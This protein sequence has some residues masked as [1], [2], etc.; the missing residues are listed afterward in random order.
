M[1]RDRRFSRSRTFFAPRSRPTL[2][3]GRAAAVAERALEDLLGVADDR[4]E[5]GRHPRD[6]GLIISRQGK[7]SFVRQRT[8]RPVGLRPHIEQAFEEQRVTI[9]FAGFSGETLNGAIQEP[10]DKIRVGRL[11]PDEIGTE[12][13]CRICRCRSAYP[14]SQQGRRRR[15]GT[16]ALG[17]DCSSNQRSATRSRSWPIWALS[18]RRR[19]GAHVPHEPA[20]RAFII[21]GDEIFS[22]F[23]L[24]LKHKVMIY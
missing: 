8:E 2:R 11:T 22:G 15:T 13:S 6:E 1:T 12:C 5:G 19:N 24:A 20:V 23:Y 16:S 14:R 17:R 7:G 4:A 21:N 3:A 18:A 10:L 9:D